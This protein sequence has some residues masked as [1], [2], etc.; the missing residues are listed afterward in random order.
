MTSTPTVG[1]STLLRQSVPRWLWLSQLFSAAGDRLYGVALIWL[2]LELTGSP[3]AVAAVTLAN[4]VPFLVV[5]L[6][7]GW[8][9]DRHDPLRLTW[10][11]DLARAVTV[12][13]VP[14]LYLTD[15]LSVISLAAAAVVHST[16]EAFFLPALQAA[17]PVI[18]PRSALAPMVSLLDSTDRLGRVIGPGL[19]GALAF[20]PV[21][22]LFTLDAA[23]FLVSAGC[24]L[25]VH[26]KLNNGTDR[27][28]AS[29]E[30]FSIPALLQGWRATLRRPVLRDALILRA[31]CN[32]AWPAFTLT[33]P[34]L[35]TGRY[36]NGIGGY[37]L[38]L[39]AFGAGNAL[40]TLIAAHVTQRWMARTCYLAWLAA[41]LG[42]FALAA[43]PT[44]TLFLAAASAIG[45]CTPL[46]N[47]TV[48]TAIAAMLPQDVLAR[49]YTAQRLAVVGAG[50]AGL[51]IAAT[52]TTIHGPAHTLAL[53]GGL[54]VTAATITL[55]TASKRPMEPL[56]PGGAE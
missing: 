54:I 8:F 1:V 30:S 50:T 2:A 44:Y 3:S 29:T 42:F 20:L 24:L 7:S 56:A 37:G 18:V 6:V 49:A 31:V 4:T 26:R 45:I 9:A 32:L 40:G 47:V 53:A 14:V 34:F 23:T 51:P 28:P 39:A 5:G 17:V 25:L 12:S 38:V 15:Q 10:F 48:N 55:V 19:V 21:V 22:H 35:V 27:N 33:I 16:L 41:G 52:I 36:H 46:A 43:A 11:V 13:A